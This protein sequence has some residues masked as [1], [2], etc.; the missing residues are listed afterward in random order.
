MVHA[1]ADGETFGQ[2]VGEFAVANKPVFT[3]GA[4]PH[5]A[6]THLERLRG[7]AQI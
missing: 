5:G 1:R 7:K 4:P 6:S 2:A 3:Y